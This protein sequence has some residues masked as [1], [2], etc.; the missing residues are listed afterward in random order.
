MTKSTNRFTSSLIPY[1][2]HLTTFEKIQM[3]LLEDVDKIPLH[4]AFNLTE[5]KLKKIY[6]GIFTYWIDRPTL[7]DKKIFNF[8]VNEYGF[9][10]QTAYKYLNAV[11]ILL[12]NVRNANKQWQRFKVIAMLDRAYEVAERRNDA[13][14]M[15]LAAD[16]LG[17]YTQLDKEDTL[18]IPYDEIVPQ[19]WIIS[20]DVTILGLEPI[21]DLHA[22][23]KELR[24][25]YGSTAIEEATL[26]DG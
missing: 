17:K 22:K 12:G 18:K 21:E 23:Q 25:K 5:L 10:R 24:I 9:S 2:E 16:R 19:N 1:P 8:I 13:K 7:S 26:I 3:Y 15:I 14:A 6:S 4:H 20:D 11:K